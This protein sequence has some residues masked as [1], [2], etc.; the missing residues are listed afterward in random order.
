MG[1]FIREVTRDK[2]QAM[3]EAV[4]KGDRLKRLPEEGKKEEMGK[5]WRTEQAAK[6]GWWQGGGAGR[7]PGENHFP[8]FPS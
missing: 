8:Y 5:A 7:A 6:E 1:H 2:E 4:G 3:P